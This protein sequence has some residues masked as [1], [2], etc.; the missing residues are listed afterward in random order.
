MRRGLSAGTGEVLAAEPAMHHSKSKVQNTDDES[1]FNGLERH[2]S[3]NH[4]STNSEAA[5][6]LQ[7]PVITHSSWAGNQDAAAVQKVHSRGA[8]SWCGLMSCC[9]CIGTGNF[10]QL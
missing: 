5:D 8:V 10:E 9:S 1:F 3:T 4:M 7:P 6:P 2:L